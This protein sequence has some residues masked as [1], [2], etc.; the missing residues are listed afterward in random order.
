MSNRPPSNTYAYTACSWARRLIASVT[1]TSPP[2][3]G[4]LAL[5]DEV[6]V[7]ERRDRTDRFGL[8][9]LALRRQVVLQLDLTVE[10]VLDGALAP[11]R[12]DQDVGD[13][14]PNRLFHH[15][16]DGRLVDDREH[17]L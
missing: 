14:G 10:V 11:P 4:C 15:V 17:L 5:A 6:D 1:C 7:P 13:P 12:D 2:T 8:V 3:P 9:V 16:L